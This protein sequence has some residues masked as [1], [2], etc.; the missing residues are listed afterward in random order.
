MKPQMSVRQGGEL[1]F[2][3]RERLQARAPCPFGLEPRELNVTLEVARLG[4]LELEIE[5]PESARKARGQQPEALAGARLDEGRGEQQIEF[6]P[7]VGGAQ[8]GAQAR[9]VASGPL[10]LEGHAERLDE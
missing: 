3:G 4:A 9:G 7:G 1:G 8:H 5:C 6:A 2:A 10:P